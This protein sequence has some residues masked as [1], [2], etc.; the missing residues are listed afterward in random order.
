MYKAITVTVYAQYP[1]MNSVLY[2]EIVHGEIKKRLKLDYTNGM[3][4]LRRLERQSG[5][6]AQLE[7]N[8]LSRT[9]CYKRLSFWE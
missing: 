1:D 5:K 9:I 7:S 2:Y 3:K 4:L 6:L 8:G